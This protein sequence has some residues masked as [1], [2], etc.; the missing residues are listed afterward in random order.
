MFLSQLT[1]NPCN[2]QVKN[3]RA[4]PYQL[5]KTLLSA[6]PAGGVHQERFEKDSHGVLFRVEKH[7]TLPAWSLLVQSHTQPDW[8]AFYAWQDKWRQPYLLKSAQLKPIN[9][10][11]AS[12]QRLVFRLRAN[13]TRKKTFIKGDPTSKKRIGIKEENEQLLWLVQKFDAATGEGEHAQP[14]G[15]Q[16]LAATITKEKWLEG[17]I[18][19]DEQKH[20]T[21]FCAVQ[22]DGVVEVID[23]KLAIKTIQA[24]IGSGKAFGFGL[25]SVAPVR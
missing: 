25:L 3:E 8:S 23:S 5:H 20:S 16:L 2:N 19:K 7:P 6:F 22:F 11:L 9:L 24:G 4:E 17:E 1:L 13:P 14:S 18:Q 21:K 12:G 10:Q 15:F